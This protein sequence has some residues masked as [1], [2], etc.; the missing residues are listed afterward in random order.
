MA[1]VAQRAHKYSAH[2]DVVMIYIGSEATY[3]QLLELSSASSIA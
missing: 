3:I 1:V 2:L